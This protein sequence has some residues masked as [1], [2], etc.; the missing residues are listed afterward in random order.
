MRRRRSSRSLLR[1]RLRPGSARSGGAAPM[2]AAAGAVQDIG[3][4]EE[5]AAMQPGGNY[6]LTADIT[7]TAPYANDFTDFSGTFDGDGH[8]VTL[9]IS[10][11]SGQCQALF[12]KAGGRRRGEERDGGR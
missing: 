12:S 11:A 3:T 7:V 10:G 8:T 2:L 4:A 9:K 5:F 6:Q 1:K